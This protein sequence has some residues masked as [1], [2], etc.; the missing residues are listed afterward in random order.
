MAVT[1]TKDLADQYFAVDSHVNYAIWD[2]FDDDLR[3]AAVAHAQRLVSR[4]LGTAVENETADSNS[5]Y[6]PD[7][8]VYEQALYMLSNSNAIANGEYTAPHWTGDDGTGQ[9]RTMGDIYTICPEARAYLD[10]QSGSTI[11]IA[12]G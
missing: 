10:V 4:A 8:A 9:A 3:T 11:P 7:R 12:R 5:Q 6:H 1:I 2:K